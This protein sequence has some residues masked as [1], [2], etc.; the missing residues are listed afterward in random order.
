MSDLRGVLPYP[1]WLPALCRLVMDV[2][3]RRVDVVGRHRVPLDGPVL[4]VA[5]HGNGLLDPI[6]VMA[7]L[8]RRPRFLGKS[9]LWSNPLL[10]PFLALAGVI[11]V[12]R[13]QDPGFD[14]SRNEGMF[15]RCQEA[16]AAGGAIAIFPEGKSHSEAGLT[17]LKTGAA[18]IVLGMSAADAARVRFV[19]VG[20]TFDD[21]TRFRSCV[22]LTVGTDFTI[23]ADLLVGT[24]DGN[25]AVRQVTDRIA[26]AL[27]EVTLNYRSWEQARIIERAVDIYLRPEPEVPGAAS[28][29]E[30]FPAVQT[31][32]EEYERLSVAEPMRLEPLAEALRHY[33]LTLARHGLRDDQVAADYHVPSV[34]K[35]VVSTL[36]LL[37]V[38]LPAALVGALLNV[39][40]YQAT[41]RF[42]GRM[43]VESEQPASWILF[44]GLFFYPL[45]WAVEAALGAWL[46][47]WAWAVWIVVLGPLGG[48][49]AMRFRDRLRLFLSE[50]RAFLRLRTA[51]PLAT[52][53]AVRRTAIRGELLALARELGYG[54]PGED[55]PGDPPSMLAADRS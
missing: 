15:A 23:P 55:P 51:G 35:F 12:Y 41:G 45:T 47:G 17:E 9:T 49:A 30:R 16:L 43:A 4:F 3:F 18:R 21:R 52:T 1:S 31:F 48:W 25:G 53:I 32:I 24:D 37:F 28:L 38:R 7:Y 33:D 42:A 5:N 27:A 13:R 39:V 6:L 54:I 44:G 14:A 34:A 8:P 36:F 26:A 40:P 22:L 46:G 10:R 20:L 50:S 11:P 19:P 29:E 2:F